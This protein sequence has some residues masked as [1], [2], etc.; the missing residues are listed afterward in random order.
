MYILTYIEPN[1]ADIPAPES[2]TIPLC[3][4][5]QP[6]LGSRRVPCY[7]GLASKGGGGRFHYHSRGQRPSKHRSS[8]FWTSRLTSMKLQVDVSST[9]APPS[10]G[11]GELSFFSPESADRNDV[12]LSGQQPGYLFQVSMRKGAQSAFS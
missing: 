4:K 3:M 12:V 1:R 7:Y 6:A 11:S 9:T 2:R 10:L 8:T 5:I